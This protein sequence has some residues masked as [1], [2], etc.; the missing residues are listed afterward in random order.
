MGTFR[1]T[2]YASMDKIHSPLSRHNGQGI[3]IPHL[4]IPP[5]ERGGGALSMILP[6]TTL[7]P[8]DDSECSYLKP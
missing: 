7:L 1:E 6:A 4:S 2:V 8:L 3:L 5:G